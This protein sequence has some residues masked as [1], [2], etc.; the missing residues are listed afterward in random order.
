MKKQPTIKKEVV[1]NPVPLVPASKPESLQEWEGWV[2]KNAIEF[3]CSA[4]I[5][6]G[7]VQTH[8]FTK[9]APAIEY[10]KL[11]DLAAPYPGIVYAVTEGGRSVPLG[12]AQY[13]EMLKLR[14][15]I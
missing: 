7:R 4:K 12:P 14:G 8:R 9:L 1:K 2:V 10:K 6:P 15:E 13:E 11:L 5:G 3:T